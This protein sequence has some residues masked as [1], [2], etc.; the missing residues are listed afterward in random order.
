MFAVSFLTVCLA[1]ISVV[2]AVQPTLKPLNLIEEFGS[3]EEFEPRVVNGHVANINQFPWQVTVFIEH[4][5]N[6]S[7][8][9]SGALLSKN[10]VLTHADCMV[11]ER[12]TYVYLGSN[13]FKSGQRF[14]VARIIVHPR[15]NTRSNHHHH[16]HSIAV[17][18]L[19]A[20]VTISASVRPIALPPSK[21]EFYAFENLLARF[22]GFGSDG[23]CLFLILCWI[24]HICV[25]WKLIKKIV[26]SFVSQATALPT[27]NCTM[28]MSAFK[29]LK[30]V[31]PFFRCQSTGNTW[32]CVQWAWMPTCI[33]V[34]AIWA[35]HWFWRTNA[36]I[37]SLASLPAL[38]T[39]LTWQKDPPVSSTLRPMHAGLEKS[40]SNI[41][42]TNRRF[43]QHRR[44]HKIA[45][46]SPP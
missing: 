13:V 16:F 24:D 41:S 17:L 23:K 32:F 3:S 40:S 1:A 19:D 8:F 10:T 5:H 38:R 43:H 4:P 2:V 26:F 6:E 39:I 45:I 30:T 37:S 7:T 27:K 9:C 11:D 33:P 35:H 25:H 15:N 22:A 21:Y 12:R 20:P 42:T 29:Q 18:V 46:T 36:S 14:E 44:T 31:R 34:T 28:S